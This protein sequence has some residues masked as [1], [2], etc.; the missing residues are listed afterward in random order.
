MVG[1][2]IGA[3]ATILIL[4]SL[5]LRTVAIGYSTGAGFDVQRTLFVGA[6][7]WRPIESPKAE[8]DRECLKQRAHA[9]GIVA[10]IAAL[11]GVELVARGPA[12]LGPERTH[13]LRFQQRIGIGSDPV[14]I[15]FSTVRVD[16]QYMAALGVPFVARSPEMRRIGRAG[17]ILTQSLSRILSPEGPAIG[18]ELTYGREGYS[19]VGIVNVAVGSIRLGR[20]PALFLTNVESKAFYPDLSLVVRTREPDRLQDAVRRILLRRLPDSSRVEVTTGRALV[21]AD[22]GAERLGAWFFSWFG[23]VELAL[24]VAS[25][26]GLVSYVIEGRRQEFGIRMALGATPRQIASLAI[27]AGL[28]PTVAGCAGGMLAALMATKA[29][30]SALVGVMRP[31][32]LAYVLAEAGLLACSSGAA[33]LAGR[34]AWR[35]TA[36][37]SMRVG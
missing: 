33:L 18:R 4:A 14:P 24:G 13:E 11:P 35:V 29:I 5:S 15:T 28:A 23:L 3:T 1:V 26:F 36:T 16:G 34:R 2:H 25:V 9:D 27:T 10:E 12:P 19:V 21:A 30:E 20:P 17:A 22:L 6:D 32:P 7:L 37:E 31:D 8:F